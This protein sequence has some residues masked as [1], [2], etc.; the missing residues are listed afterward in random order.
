MVY[1]RWIKIKDSA[2]SVSVSD[3]FICLFWGG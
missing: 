3:I 2:V 1:V